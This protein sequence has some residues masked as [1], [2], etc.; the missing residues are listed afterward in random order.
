MSKETDREL[1]NLAYNVS[2]LR[3]QHGLSKT[4]MAKLLKIG[5]GTLGK[6]EDGEIPAAL[7]VDIFFG[8]QKH[9]GIRPRDLLAQRL[10]EET[11]G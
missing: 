3:R 8:L 2:L 4:E 6:L 10:E 7:T 9:F 11:G 1:E 5:A